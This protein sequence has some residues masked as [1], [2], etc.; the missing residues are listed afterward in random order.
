MSFGDTTNAAGYDSIVYC[1]NPAGKMAGY[2]TYLIHYGMGLV[3]PIQQFEPTWTGSNVVKTV[4][5]ELAGSLTAL[6]LIETLTFL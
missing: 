3:E 1:Y 2:I 5:Y 4:E 6:K